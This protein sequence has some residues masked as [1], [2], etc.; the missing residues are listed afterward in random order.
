[1]GNKAARI[2]LT[3]L[4]RAAR[5]AKEFNVVVEIDLQS[6][7]VRF[8]PDGKPI[9]NKDNAEQVALCEGVAL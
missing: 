9:E 4:A 6:E 8:V 3:E 7:T 1:M 5:V 2:T